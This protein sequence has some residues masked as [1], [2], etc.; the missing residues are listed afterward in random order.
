M[1]TTDP[2]NGDTAEAFKAFPFAT[3]QEYQVSTHCGFVL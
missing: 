1:A 3:D 2:N